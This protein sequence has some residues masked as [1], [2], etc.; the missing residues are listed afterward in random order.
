MKNFKGLRRFALVLVM[1]LVVL[2]MVGCGSLAYSTPYVAYIDTEGEVVILPNYVAGYPFN[3]GYAQVCI[4]V[5]SYMYW[6]FI[7]EYGDLAIGTRYFQVTPVSEGLFAAQE[8]EDDPW[9]FYDVHTGELAFEGEWKDVGAFN[10]GLAPVQQM[11]A[12]YLYGYIDTE[13]NLVMDYQFDLASDF[14]D[15]GLALFR[16]GGQDSGRCGYINLEGNVVIEPTL[17]YGSTFADGFSLV[18]GSAD[19]TAADWGF[20]NEQGEMVLG[21][22]YAGAW[23]F[24]DGL[25]PVAVADAE[26]NLTWGYID[27]TGAWVIEPQFVDASSFS[28]GV[29]SVGILPEGEQYTRYGYIDAEGNW[30]IEPRFQAAGLFSEGMAPVILQDEEAAEVG[31]GSRN[32][33]AAQNKDK[34]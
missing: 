27:A 16:D 7:D 8:E 21:G 15:N 9:Q 5:S 6:G 26:G 28:E 3:E 14:A 32:N 31:G 12:P 17:Y 19:E 10:Q 24:C 11:D 13:G 30:V 29:A 22:D 2:S 20:I 18:K 33:P 25:A 34:D 23:S 1:A 4:G